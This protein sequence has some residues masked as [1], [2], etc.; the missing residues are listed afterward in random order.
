MHG[1]SAN[2]RR[3]RQ[4]SAE[5]RA[6]T[7][8]ARK[9][10]AS[11]PSRRAPAIIYQS[12]GDNLQT[13]LAFFTKRAPGPADSQIFL[14]SSFTKPLWRFTKQPVRV[15]KNTPRGFN[16]SRGSRRAAACNW[17]RLAAP[18]GLRFPAVPLCRADTPVHVGCVALFET[19]RSE[20]RAPPVSRRVLNAWRPRTTRVQLWKTCKCK[21]PR[22]FTYG[23]RLSG[24]S[25]CG[26]I[27]RPLT[28]VNILAVI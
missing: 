3:R 5:R 24:L 12:A 7:A 15:Y 19:E 28:H 14:M 21:G 26:W 2:G 22:F 13:P 25:S 23:P 11:A 20:G 18:L 6:P 9:P 8:A 17:R 10:R 16:C 1:A 27:F 4:V